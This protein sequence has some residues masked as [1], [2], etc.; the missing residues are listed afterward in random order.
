VKRIVLMLL[1]FALAGGAAA[2]SWTPFEFPPGDQ[3]YVVD[4]VTSEGVARVDVDVAARGGLFDVTT[5]MTF[6]QTGVDPSSM[7]DAFFGGSALAMFGFGPMVLFGP[8]AFMLPMMLGQEDIAVRK[9]PMRLMGV[10]TLVMD[11]E[12]IVAGRRCV[13]ITVNMDGGD[14]LVF[15]IAEGVPIPCFT[16]YGTGMN[17]MEVRLVE[18]R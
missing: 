11:R 9:E 16:R 15:A 12:E 8:S 13:V 1:S 2:F 10:G 5:T 4:I 6:E 17:A 18:V 3:G 7:G 14:Q